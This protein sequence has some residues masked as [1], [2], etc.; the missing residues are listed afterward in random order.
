[1]ESFHPLNSMGQ[2]QRRQVYYTVHTY[3]YMSALY[4]HTYTHVREGEREREPSSFLRVP[5]LYPWPS[6]NERERRPRWWWWVYGGQSSRQKIH[7]TSRTRHR[8]VVPSSTRLLFGIFFCVLFCF[9]LANLNP[10]AKLAEHLTDILQKKKKKSDGTFRFVHSSVQGYFFFF[11]TQ[12]GETF[13]TG[14]GFILKKKKRKNTCT[15]N[16]RG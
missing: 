16:L 5:T 9:F 12:P 2:L 8:S 3:L 11:S 15:H 6:S 4:T 1:M 14:R 10:S 7:S 13:F